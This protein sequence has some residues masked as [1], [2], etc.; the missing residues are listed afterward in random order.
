MGHLELYLGIDGNHYLEP[1]I[2]KT[3]D[4]DIIARHP[5]ISK[6]V[7]GRASR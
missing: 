1:Q 6:M 3:S 2:F 4:L 5:K 7:D